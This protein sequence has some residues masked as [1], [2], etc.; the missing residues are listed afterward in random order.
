[1]NI[2]EVSS[3]ATVSESTDP[4]RLVEIVP[5]L[6]VANVASS[7]R[8]YRDALGFDITFAWYDDARV[9][10]GD[11]ALDD[12]TAGF[13]G[14][15]RDGQ[16]LFFSRSDQAKPQSLYVGVMMQYPIDPLYEAF[17]A[18]GALAL[19]PP[20][21][22]PWDVREFLM[23]DLDGHH[24]RFGIAADRPVNRHGPV[25]HL[26]GITPELNVPDVVEA[27]RWYSDKM[28]FKTGFLVQDTYG[29]VTRDGLSIFFVK[30]AGRQAPTRCTINLAHARDVDVYFS[31]LRNEDVKII[32]DVREQPWGMREFVFEDLNGYLY[33]IGAGSKD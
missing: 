25:P 26:W 21:D 3:E 33:R 6:N 1:M 20:T 22:Q 32:E 19:E 13:G 12:P 16:H 31:D 4:I 5:E 7:Q 17:I 11:T 15:S 10:S 29:S 18:A 14:V 30:K 8:Y 23:N 24:L 28:G 2:P 27:Q 9:V